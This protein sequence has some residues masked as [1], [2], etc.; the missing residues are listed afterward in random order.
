MRR[1]VLRVVVITLLLLGL[2]VP[3]A[4][5]GALTG[6]VRGTVKDPDGGVL[7]GV[8]V[9]ATSDA[10]VA[11]KLT[12]VTDERGVYRFPSL[13]PGAYVIEAELSGFKTTR[14]EGVRVSLGRRT[15]RRP[16]PVDGGDRRGDHRDGG[17]AG[18]QRG[19]EHGGDELRRRASSTSSRCRATTTRCSPR[20]RA[21]PWT[22]APPAR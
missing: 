2:A 16:R 20:R 19:V 11:G 21:S 18:G 10:L 12:A 15:R 17:R 13:P 1:D 4:A 22:S 7:P 3:L 6:S 14:Q 5:Q 9:T 8:T